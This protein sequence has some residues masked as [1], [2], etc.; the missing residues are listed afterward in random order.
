MRE[1]GP[2]PYVRLRADRDSVARRLADQRGARSHRVRSGSENRIG[3][4][5][6]RKGREATDCREMAHEG[7]PLP[8]IQRQLGHAHLGI[9]SIYL[10]GIDTREIVDTIHHRRPPVILQAPACGVSERPRGASDRRSR[11]PPAP[12]SRSRPRR[13]E[14]Y[15]CCPIPALTPPAAPLLL[16]CLQDSFAWLAP[17]ASSSGVECSRLLCALPAHC[18]SDARPSVTSIYRCKFGRGS[19]SRVESKRL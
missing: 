10:Q 14:R 4:R 17:S 11:A 3:A 2:S 7:I 5:L 18:G 12:D 15:A 16:R 1:A 8:I 19:G 9:T 6:R 13:R